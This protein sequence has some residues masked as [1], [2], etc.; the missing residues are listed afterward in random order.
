[1]T[2]SRLLGHRCLLLLYL[3]SSALDVEAKG[4]GDVKVAGMTFHDSGIIEVTDL[5]LQRA[6][7]WQHAQVGIWSPVE[8]R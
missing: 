1:M 3:I 8:V 7:T 6:L 4:L 2:G 5:F